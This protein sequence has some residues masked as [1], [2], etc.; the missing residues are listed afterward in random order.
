MK[1]I[2]I[3]SGHI[4]HC[5][6]VDSSIEFNIEVFVN[7]LTPEELVIEKALALA[8]KNSA[9][10][11]LANNTVN[12]EYIMASGCEKKV[13]TTRSVETIREISPQAQEL[14]NSSIHV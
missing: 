9:V 3:F 5:R 12:V 4:V 7:T 6:D 13:T 11:L 1:Q 14:I 8:R 2:S 10:E